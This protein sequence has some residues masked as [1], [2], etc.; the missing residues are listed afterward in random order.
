MLVVCQDLSVEID[1]GGGKRATAEK[2]R[3]EVGDEGYLTWE[4]R[5]VA[6]EK[7]KDAGK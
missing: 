6:E 3:R 5:R 7:M 1:D 2:A 4:V